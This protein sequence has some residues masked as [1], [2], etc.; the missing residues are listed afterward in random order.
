[1]AKKRRLGK[2]LLLS[3]ILILLLGGG[4]VFTR[5]FEVKVNPK[6]GEET[7]PLPSEKSCEEL[8]KA[9]I[10]TR[11]VKDTA[12]VHTSRTQLGNVGWK[13]WYELEDGS[14]E[15]SPRDATS[16]DTFFFMTT[17]HAVENHYSSISKCTE[18]IY[19]LNPL[20]VRGDRM[21]ELHYPL[22]ISDEQTF[23]LMSETKF[24]DKLY[25]NLYICPE[26]EGSYSV[27]AD[28]TTFEGLEGAT[29]IDAKTG[30]ESFTIKGTVTI[31]D[32][33]ASGIDIWQE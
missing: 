18:G 3:L 1:M 14:S 7:D 12:L 15:C 32:L 4:F 19:N 11:C 27:I 2:V 28:G 21:Q 17:G 8:S 22:D 31:C 25:L 10:C 5:F 16:R 9:D 29:Y 6:N 26:S 20:L 24:F 30:T 13:C 33:S 23:K